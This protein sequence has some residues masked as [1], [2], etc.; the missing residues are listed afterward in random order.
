MSTAVPTESTDSFQ[1]SALDEYFCDIEDRFDGAGRVA[2]VLRLEGTVEPGLLRASL[3]GVQTRHPKLGTTIAKGADGHRHYLPGTAGAIPLTIIDVDDDEFPRRDQTRALLDSPLG[4]DGNA[5][6][7]VSIVRDRSRDQSDLIIVAHHAVADGLSLIAIADDLLSQYATLEQQEQLDP[8]VSLPLITR[9]AVAKSP[10]VLDKIR[11]LARLLRVRRE[12]RRCRWTSLPE[13]DPGAIK[14]LAQWQHWVFDKKVTAALIR[15]CR[16]RD[17]SLTAVL[18][19]AAICGLMDCIQSGTARFKCRIPIDVRAELDSPTGSL[20]DHDLGCFVSEF[21]TIYLLE[22]PNA[23]WNVAEMAHRDVERFVRLGGPSFLYGLASNLKP[24]MGQRCDK[25]GTVFVTSFGKLSLQSRYGSLK[26]L[27]FTGLFKHDSAGPLL[28]IEAFVLRRQLN[29]GISA[30]SLDA[31][32]WQDLQV[33]MRRHLE[34]TIRA[35][36]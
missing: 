2:L 36:A 13:A 11:L 33:A 32:F 7:A 9:V 34:I 22:G 12:N 18:L 26:P 19:A 28:I 17:V 15:S 16:E 6:A 25:R 5:P 10:G 29:L 20:T 21:Q 3:S 24:G 23:V 4:I 35:S 14:P 27:Y 30:A 31:E 8:I 1:L